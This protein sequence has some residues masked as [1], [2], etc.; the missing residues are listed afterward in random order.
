M[1]LMAGFLED[2][3]FKPPYMIKTSLTTMTILDDINFMLIVMK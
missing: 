3:K 1:A 2:E